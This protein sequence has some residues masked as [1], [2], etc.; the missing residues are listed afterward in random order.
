MKWSLPFF[1]IELCPSHCNWPNRP[2][3][4]DAAIVIL[5]IHNNT[6]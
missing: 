3:A 6:E 4:I 5:F 2:V 1:Y